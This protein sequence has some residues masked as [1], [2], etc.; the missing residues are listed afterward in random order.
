MIYEEALKILDLS[1]PPSPKEVKQNYRLKAL[2]FHPDRN[3]HPKA[4]LWFRQ[5][6][7]A[8]AYLAEHADEW[9]VINKNKKA[10]DHEEE[11]ISIDDIDDIFDDIFGFTR[12]DRILGYHAPQPIE[13][14]LNEL[15]FGVTKVMKMVAYEKCNSCQGSGAQLKG[16]SSICTYC[17]GSGV[18]ASND[19][20]SAHQPCPK[21]EGRGRKILHPCPICLGFGRREIYRPQEVSL[22]SGLSLNQ[23]YTVHSKDLK[24]GQSCDS[25][26]YLTLK[27]HSFF[28]VENYDLVCQYPI[29]LK[30]LEVGSEIRFPT[31]WGWTS[32]VIDEA[33]CEQMRTC[34]KGKG[35]LLSPG[36]SKRGDVYI[37][38]KKTALGKCQRLRTKILNEVAK[39]NPSY[40]VKR[41]WWQRFF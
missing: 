4:S 34:I 39:G 38:F 40:R 9:T 15:A 21:C 28:K 12:Q 16:R 29:N 10:S 20:Q 35:L 13:V 6:T 8:Y 30:E 32:L 37:E 31:L 3:A 26:I 19:G 23:A 7:E 18:V 22:V 27:N 24:S 11:S 41:S 33:A 2:E 14:D 5:I 17:F 25:Y 36:Q 1:D